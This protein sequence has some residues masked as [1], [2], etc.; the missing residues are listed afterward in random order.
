MLK[1]SIKK[2]VEG[3]LAS[4]D[5]LGQRWRD[6]AAALS[7]H[8]QPSF[9]SV[10]WDK[11]QFSKW[12]E[13]KVDSKF[14]QHDLVTWKH[15]PVNRNMVPYHMSIGYINE[16]WRTIE[17][18]VQNNEPKCIHLRML[19]GISRT[20]C[21]SELRLLT[22]EEVALVDLQNTKAKGTA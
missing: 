5:T 19:N 11:I 4:M 21:P 17:F 8:T 7:V 3:F 15:V 12:M 13:D 1:Y 6:R 16:L 14:K 20:A 10:P 2:P 9:M 18:S 22:P